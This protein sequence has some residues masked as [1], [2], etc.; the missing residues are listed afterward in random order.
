MTRKPL[1]LEDELAVARNRIEELEN[2]GLN[3]DETRIE[4]VDPEALGDEL[5]ASND[6]SNV[7]QSGLEDL[8]EE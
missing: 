8:V 4:P 3:S 5:D 6:P 2:W 7:T 1:A